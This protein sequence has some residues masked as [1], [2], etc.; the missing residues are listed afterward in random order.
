[1]LTACINYVNLTTARA[2]LRAKEVSVRK[3]VGAGRAQLF[4]QFMAESLVVSSASLLFAILI[5]ELA[6]PGFN[7]LTGK[8]FT[9]PLF[10]ASTW[11]ILGGTLI[12]S[13][14]LNGLYPAMLLSSFKP[15]SV[16]RGKSVLSFKDTSLRKS[17]VTLQFAISVV[18][19]TGTI[20]IYRQ[21]NYMQKIDLGYNKEHTFIFTLQYWRIPGF[22]RK[23]APALLHTV[24]QELEHRTEFAMVSQANQSL[25]D[26][27]NSSSGG[28]DWHGRPKDVNPT[29]APFNADLNFNMI[30]Q[31]KLT[32]G[33]WFTA[34]DKHNVL[35][36]ET[37]V[38]QT[39]IQKPVIGQFLFTRAIPG[40]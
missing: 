16:F 4:Y 9:Q 8:H 22:N 24:R 12:A 2:S 26:F 19:I 10:Q 29:F 33:H 5:V 23:S 38:K 20:V 28:F 18:L 7:T 1:L 34:A 37:A 30:T 39:G 27:N 21:L 17:L 13:F 14:V 6:I 31:L 25:V 36:N 11:W 32:E 15:M 35:L 40:W 3:I